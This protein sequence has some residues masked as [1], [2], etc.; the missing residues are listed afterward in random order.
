MTAKITCVYD[1][2]SQPNTSL[3]GAK[4]TAMLVEKDGKRIFFNV[5]L[6]DRYLIHNMEYLDIDPNTIDI[7]VVSQSNPCASGALNGLLKN[8]EGPL[9]VYCP[10]GL[11]GSK[12]FMSR[13]VS[14]SKENS[15]KPIFHDIG[16]WIELI[17]GVFITPFYYDPKGYGETFMVIVEGSRVAL[18][19]GR[20]SCYPDKVISDVQEHIGKKV[21]AFIG[22]VLL[23]KK[24][25]PVAAAYAEMLASVPDLYLNHCVGPDGIVNLR[26]HLGLDGVSDFYVGDVYNL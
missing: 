6:R 14:L 24:K 1:E 2:G 8:R 11:Y 13:S 3:I 25:K 15:E 26:V 10:E 16:A 20:C 9:D 7:A 5:G 12:S 18:L 23:E 17:P 19:S 22:P 21:T 4:G